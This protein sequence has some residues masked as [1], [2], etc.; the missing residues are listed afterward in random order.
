MVELA[1]AHVWSAGAWHQ[2]PPHARVT[3]TVSDVL[4]VAIDAAFTGDPAPPAPASAMPGLWDFEVVECFIA[5]PPWDRSASYV[6][7]ELGPHGHWLAWSFAGYRNRVGD[8]AIA[9]TAARAG[10]RWS[11]RI[12]VPL[13]VLPPRPW[14]VHAAAIHGP[15]AART[16]VVATP[17]GGDRPDFHRVADFVVGL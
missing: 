2:R 16:H 8:V 10:P 13:D 6:E 1:V 7:L 17:L 12:V 11:G 14:R 9:A 5:G 15:A 4:E 3:L